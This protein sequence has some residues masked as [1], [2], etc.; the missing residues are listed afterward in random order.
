MGLELVDDPRAVAAAPGEF[1]ARIPAGLDGR[2]ALFDAL[3][4]ALRL[5]DYFGRN[6]D[7]L[8]ECLRDLGWI[9][10]RRVLLVHEDLPRLPARDGR[11]YLEL[12]RDDAGE[13]LAVYFPSSARTEI[14]AL[15]STH[16]AR[17]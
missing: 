14:D 5:P 17:P 11:I 1:L 15:C 9:G 10:A 8:D 3:T 7:A 6:W 4:R 13:G 12:L 2:D 16:H